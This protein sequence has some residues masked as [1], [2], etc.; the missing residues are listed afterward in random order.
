MGFTRERV[1]ARGK[2][3][4]AATY[5]D[6]RG[7]QRSAGT[8]SNGPRAERASDPLL[9]ARSA[10]GTGPHRH[11]FSRTRSRSV[12]GIV[13]RIKAGQAAFVRP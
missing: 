2:M 4:Y 9:R 3:R 13:C 11:Q 7:Q 1:A 5:R 12:T 10:P 6:L 8:F